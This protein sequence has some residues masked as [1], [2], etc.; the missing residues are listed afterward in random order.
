M[1]QN[2]IPNYDDEI[3]FLHGIGTAGFFMVFGVSTLGSEFTVSAYPEAWVKRYEDRDYMVGD[4]ALLFAL[5]STGAKRWSEMRFEDPRGVMVDAALHGLRFGVTVAVRD[6]GDK[7]SF[8]SLARSDRELTDN[9]I[10]RVSGRFDL[11][12]SRVTARGRPSEA[13]LD[14]LRCFRDGMSIETTAQKLNVSASTVK[15]RAKEATDCLRA[16]TRSQA[17]AIAVARKFI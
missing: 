6:D 1:L 17:V 9:E 7:K 16:T 14:V 4:P 3:A 15:Y 13:Q 11:W 12:T 10:E 5:T 2:L 8:L